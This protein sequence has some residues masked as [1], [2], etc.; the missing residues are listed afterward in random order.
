MWYMYKILSVVGWYW[1]AFVAL[2]LMIRLIPWRRKSKE[3]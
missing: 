2:Y 1:T 3:S